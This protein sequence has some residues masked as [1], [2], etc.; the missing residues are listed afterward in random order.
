M[1]SNVILK[2]LEVSFLG[3]VSNLLKFAVGSC[4]NGL[5]LSAWASTS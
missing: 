3:E 1:V 5:F 4:E 2:A